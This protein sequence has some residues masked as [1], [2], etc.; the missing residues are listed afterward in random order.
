MGRRS[1]A[2]RPKHV[3]YTLRYRGGKGRTFNYHPASAGIVEQTQRVEN[4]RLP[5]PPIR[6]SAMQSENQLGALD[7][8]LVVRFCKNRKPKP[9]TENRN[10]KNKKQEGA[11]AKTTKAHRPLVRGFGFRFRLYIA[12]GLVPPSSF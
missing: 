8:A 10:N 9:K 7:L 2:A 3:P 6:G 5:L 4:Q 12:A 11:K 1:H